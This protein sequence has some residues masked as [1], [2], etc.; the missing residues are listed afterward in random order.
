MQINKQIF[1]D[2]LL[3]KLKGTFMLRNGNKIN[4]SDIKK[5][6]NGCYDIYP[7]RTKNYPYTANGCVYENSISDYDIID[8]IPESYMKEIELKK[9]SYTNLVSEL[10]AL[11]AKKFEYQISKNCLMFG[12]IEFMGKETIVSALA[13]IIEKSEYKERAASELGLDPKKVKTVKQV[14]GYTVDEWKAD[15]KLRL[16]QI[17]VEKRIEKLEKKCPQLLEILD[18]A[19]KK[20]IVLDQINASLAEEED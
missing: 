16:E 2:V 8:F 19:D 3:G 18:D 11:K 7:Y 12:K 10:K 20:G 15:F 1:E 4:T 14:E 5:N 6:V 13:K 17:K 9:D